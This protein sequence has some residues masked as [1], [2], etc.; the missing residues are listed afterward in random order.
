MNDN[1]RFPAEWEPQSAVLM[2][3][4]HAGTDWADR[5]DAVQHRAGVGQREGGFQRRQLGGHGGGGGAQQVGV[6][7]RGFGDGGGRQVR[8]VRATVVASPL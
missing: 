7:S 5:L 3:W 4:P 1:L 6:P 2:A 8:W